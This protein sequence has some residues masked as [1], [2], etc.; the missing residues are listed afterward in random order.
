MV[1]PNMMTYPRDGPPFNSMW[2]MTG[3]ILP[4]LISEMCLLIV[5]NR[6]A[7][8]HAAIHARVWDAGAWLQFSNGGAVA[9]FTNQIGLIRGKCQCS[10][11]HSL[12]TTSTTYPWISCFSANLAVAEYLN[13]CNFHC[14]SVQGLE[15]HGTLSNHQR[16]V[17]RRPWNIWVS[18]SY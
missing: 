5:E 7:W 3:D 16:S 12:T 15:K 2:W 14:T 4:Y 1:W 11:L 8:G 17:I 9:Y 18:N 10:K 6:L 13:G